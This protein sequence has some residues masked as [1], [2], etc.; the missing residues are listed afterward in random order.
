MKKNILFFTILIGVIFLSCDSEEINTTNNSTNSYIKKIITTDIDPFVTSEFFYNSDNKINH[1]TYPNSN[2][3]VYVTYENNIV[4]NIS[5]VY[6]SFTNEYN[7]EYSNNTISILSPNNSYEID[8][9]NEYVD[10][11][12][13]SNF[14]NEVEY[15]FTR[16]SDNNIISLSQIGDYSNGSVNRT[17]NYSNFDSKNCIPVFG[18]LSFNK[19]FFLIFNLK[20][21]NNNPLTTEY[22]N[23]PN[24]NTFMYNSAFEYDE[25]DNVILNGVISSQSYVEYEYIQL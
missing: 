3:N 18:D 5:E 9:S 21:S 19:D 20:H 11:Y 16:N 22:T 2:H 8:Y 12:R 25:N 17:Y 13:T 23:N 24:P 15:V 14:S 10:A 1:I 4:T 6:P 7:V